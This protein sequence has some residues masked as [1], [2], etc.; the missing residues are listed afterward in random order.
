MLAQ[1]PALAQRADFL[2]A[3][4]KPCVRITIN[5]QGP[6]GAQSQFGGKPMVP[7]GFAWPQHAVG[8]YRFLGQ[9]NFAE[10]VNRPADLPDIGLL[11]LFYAESVPNTPDD[12][13]IFW[14]RGL[15]E[16]LNWP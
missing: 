1:Q 15:R 3:L 14:R 6:N 2:R 10:I 12:A 5:Q 13:E 7:P 16:S 4:L 8:V 9:I 11:V